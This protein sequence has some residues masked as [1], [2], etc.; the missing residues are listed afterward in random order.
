MHLYSSLYYILHSLLVAATAKASLRL[1]A[2]PQKNIA[3]LC[4]TQTRT[5]LSRCA[6]RAH[7]AALVFPAHSRRRAA[8]RWACSST[9]ASATVASC[10]TCLDWISVEQGGPSIKCA[11]SVH[12]ACI[13]RVKLRLESGCA[14]AVSCG[15]VGHKKR[16]RVDTRRTVCV[17]PGPYLSLCLRRTAEFK[18]HSTSR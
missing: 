17:C 6:F 5:C 15:S 16:Q 2:T 11:S 8:S 14:A 7:S 18:R 12:Q 1:R 3:N 4:R 9:F 10:S 13:K